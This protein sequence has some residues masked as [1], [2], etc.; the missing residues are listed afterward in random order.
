[1]PGIAAGVLSASVVVTGTNAGY[2]WNEVIFGNFANNTGWSSTGW[3]ASS[4]LNSSQ[5]TAAT[6]NWSPNGSTHYSLY[7][8]AAGSGLLGTK[9]ATAATWTLNYTLTIS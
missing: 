8:H 6:A 3:T 7:S 2:A 9:P 5:G 4:K 1:L